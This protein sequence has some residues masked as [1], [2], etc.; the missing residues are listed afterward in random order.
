MEAAGDPMKLLH[1]FC[2]LLAL[3]ILV[4]CESA[5]PEPTTT[6]FV[7]VP[8]ATPTSTPAPTATSLP[9]PTP[10]LVRVTPLDGSRIA[11]VTR[12]FSPPEN[13]GSNV[14][15]LSESHFS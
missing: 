12:T 4:A 14:V 13:F 3:L 9:L 15:V 1:G 2:A 5:P 7:P 6:P 11:L 10:T 8:T